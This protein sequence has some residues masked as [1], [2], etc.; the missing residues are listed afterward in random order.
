MIITIIGMETNKKIYMK[1]SF[2]NMIS[3]KFIHMSFIS[4]IIIVKKLFKGIKKAK[5]NILK[6]EKS[7]NKEFFPKIKR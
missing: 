1:S 5:N 7:K 6:K 3:R 2:I 4:H